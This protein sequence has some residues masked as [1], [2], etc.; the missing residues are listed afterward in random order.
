MSV[1]GSDDIPDSLGKRKAPSGSD[2]RKRQQNMT[3][4]FNAMQAT[5]MHMKTEV[6]SESLLTA[7]EDGAPSETPRGV[8]SPT[9][10][11]AQGQESPRLPADAS[12]AEAPA[13]GLPGA[14]KKKKK[15]LCIFPSV[16]SS[17]NIPGTVY[18]GTSVAP[19]P[20]G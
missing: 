2:N 3:L 13:K 19:T 9:T 8:Q 12:A 1:D 4:L 7:A 5:A 6:P 18:V 14:G 20:A 11:A 17:S 15:R 10:P 16:I